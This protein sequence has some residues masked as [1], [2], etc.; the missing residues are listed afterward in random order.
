VLRLIFSPQGMDRPILAPP[1]VPA[2]RVAALRKAFDAATKD[3]RW[4]AEAQKQNLEIDAV[5]GEKVA[6]IIEEAYKSSPEVIK[7]AGEATATSGN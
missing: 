1:G 5:P 6:K 3:P 7:A 4:L 2:E